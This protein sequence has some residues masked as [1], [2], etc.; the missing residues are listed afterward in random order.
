MIR[1]VALMASAL[2]VF[3]QLSAGA[4]AQHPAAPAIPSSVSGC[5]DTDF[6]DYMAAEDGGK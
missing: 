3:L 6:N 4:L 5:I 2:L 1:P